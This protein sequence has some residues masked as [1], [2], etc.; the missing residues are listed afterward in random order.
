MADVTESVSG[1]ICPV[2]DCRNH[3]PYECLREYWQDMDCD[4]CG[5][6]LQYKGVQAPG[7]SWEV[8]IHTRTI[9]V[10]DALYLPMKATYFDQIMAGEKREQYR[11]TNEFWSKRLDRRRYRRI[12]MTRGY[13]KGGGIQGQTRL[14]LDW[15]GSTI[16]TITHPHF[17][18]HPVQVFAIDVTGR[19]EVNHGI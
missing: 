19:R 15:R 18:P 4:R 7:T 5:Q 17:G 10:L 2:C 8:E 1:V 9:A 12:V 6:A 14:T 13:P 16:K 11:L 3:M